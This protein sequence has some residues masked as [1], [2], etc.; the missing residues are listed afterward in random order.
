MSDGLATASIPNLVSGQ[1]TEKS[2]ISRHHSLKGRGVLTWKLWR[3]HKKVYSFNDVISNIFRFWLNARPSEIMGEGG[4][5][6][7]NV[8][9]LKNFLNNTLKGNFNASNILNYIFSPFTFILTIPFFTQIFVLAVLI[10]GLPKM[11]GKGNGN[12]NS[13]FI[14]GTYD[15]QACVCSIVD[16]ALNY[17]EFPWRSR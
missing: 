3:G 5:Q 9:D 13:K 10:K 2:S 17:S 7:I 16:G 12:S 4:L 15:G 1:W 8:M 6:W 11:M 14:F